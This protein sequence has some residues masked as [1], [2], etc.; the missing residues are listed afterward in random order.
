M[1][2]FTKDQEYGNRIDGQFRVGEAFVLVGAKVTDR[3]ISTRFGDAT[4]AELHCQPMG[5]DGFSTGRDILCT[6]VATAIVAK[7]GEA[8]DDDF[9]AVVELRRVE[10]K[11]NGGEALV[12]QFVS[13]YYSPGQA[14]DVGPDGSTKRRR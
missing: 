14:I 12:L 9:P 8:A 3:M 10:S 7:C 2:M 5:E 11:Q 4:V 6:T 1:G 13:R